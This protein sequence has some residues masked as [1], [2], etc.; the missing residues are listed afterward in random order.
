MNIGICTGCMAAVEFDMLTTCELSKLWKRFVTIG[1]LLLLLSIE[2]GAVE[3]GG[4]WL[5]NHRRSPTTIGRA[6]FPMPIWA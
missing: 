3:F 1:L 2:R 5:N 4:D 6:T